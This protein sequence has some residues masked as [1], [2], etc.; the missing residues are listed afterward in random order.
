MKAIAIPFLLLMLISCK[1]P[2]TYTLNT[3]SDHTDSTLIK[4]IIIADNDSMAYKEAI[5]KF[6]INQKISKEVNL[7]MKTTGGPISFELRQGKRNVLASIPAGIKERMENETTSSLEKV[8]RNTVVETIKAT[9]FDTIGLSLA[10]IKILKNKLIEKKY[11][12][13]KD[14]CL[15]YINVSNKTISA[16]KFSW[17]GVTALSEPAEMGNSV[18][19]GFGK[20]VDDNTLRVG[21]SKTGT[22]IV[23]SRNAKNILLAW[24]TEV[25]FNDGTKWKTK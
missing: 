15:T 5:N 2:Y 7:A 9:L 13:Y 8:K 6:A 20:G 1:Q 12:N 14:V 10:P 4:Q 16:I 22:W 19:K 3:T 18:I 21:K 11:S 24:P 25:V 17:Y 23:S